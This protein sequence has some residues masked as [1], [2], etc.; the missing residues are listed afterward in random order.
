MREPKEIVQQRERLAWALRQEGW[1]QD[2]IAVELGIGQPAVSKALKRLS[3]RYHKDMAAD[4]ARVKGEQIAQ[5]DRVVD[6]AMQAWERSK[7]SA[8]SLSKITKPG[9][10]P[11]GQRGQQEETTLR[12]DD[13][14]GDP[15]HLQTAM[16]A[17]EDIRKITGANAP[18]E[19]IHDWREHAE[20]HGIDA[21]EVF[22]A[23]VQYFARQ[24][25]GSAGPDDSAGDDS[26]EEGD[27]MGE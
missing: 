5:L 12:V 1:T 19:V 8:K 9:S 15:R 23:M 21:D 25:E 18:D 16:K 6:E 4:V 14:V 2:R 22:E 27:G 7:Q 24:I 20:K 3:I 26:P 13:Q 10:G 17:M 11:R